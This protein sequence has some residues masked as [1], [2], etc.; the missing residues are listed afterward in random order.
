M[1]DSE[2]LK[3][4]SFGLSAIRG[5]YCIYVDGAAIA[6]NVAEGSYDP[7]IT[8]RE[9]ASGE[10]MLARDVWWTGHSR[11]VYRTIAL[12]GTNVQGW[13]ETDSDIVVNDGGVISLIRPKKSSARVPVG[14][15][16]LPS[17]IRGNRV[18]HLDV[19]T[20]KRNR[21]EGRDAPVIAVRFP[22]DLSLEKAVFVREAHWSGPSRILHRPTTPIPNTNGRGAAFVETDSKILV[23]RDGLTPEKV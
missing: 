6:K 8:I 18:V 19:P 7:V 1:R 10:T 12:P 20:L 17:M 9:T 16:S 4:N 5:R 15:A 2:V 11:F 3:I 13:I 22:P 21:A 23:L 14:M